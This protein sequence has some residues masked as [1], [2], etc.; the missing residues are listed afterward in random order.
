MKPV[1]G[2][3]EELPDCP[4]VGHRLYHHAGLNA[5]DDDDCD[6]DPDFYLFYVD[7]LG[8]D[9]DDH[10]DEFINDLTLLVPQF[11]RVAED[12]FTMDYRYP[13]CAVQAFGVALSR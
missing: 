6:S 13:M 9:H 4:R 11:G 12:I 1:A 2:V 5:V 8:R 7:G 10:D 3:C